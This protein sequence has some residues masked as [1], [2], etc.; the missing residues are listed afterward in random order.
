MREDYNQFKHTCDT[1]AVWYLIDG[2][3]IFLVVDYKDKTIVIN[4]PHGRT[5]RPLAEYDDFPGPMRDFAA[6]LIR[7]GICLE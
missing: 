3:D 4:T 1:A 6:A 7:E 5:V 2:Q